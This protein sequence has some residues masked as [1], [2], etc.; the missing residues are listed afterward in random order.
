MKGC[1]RFTTS[2]R[3]PKS[4]ACFALSRLH[5]SQTSL[6]PGSS[7]VRLLC[8]LRTPR[9]ALYALAGLACAQPRRPRITVRA[10]GRKLAARMASRSFSCTESPASPGRQQ[11]VLRP[12]Q[13]LRQSFMLLS[14]LAFEPALSHVA[15][16]TAPH[17]WASLEA[18]AGLS[19]YSELSLRSRLSAVRSGSRRSSDFASLTTVALRC[20][21]VYSW[22]IR[23]STDVAMCS[24]RAT[25]DTGSRPSAPLGAEVGTRRSVLAR[26]YG[27][28][29]SCRSVCCPSLRTGPGAGGQGS[30]RAGALSTRETEAA[31]SLAVLSRRVPPRPCSTAVMKG[32]GLPMAT[33][34]RLE[35]GGRLSSSNCTSSPSRRSSP[36]GCGSTVM[37]APACSAIEMSSSR[38][39]RLGRSAVTL[40]SL[41]MWP[42]VMCSRSRGMNSSKLTAASTCCM[43]G[44][45][46]ASRVS[47]NAGTSAS[48]SEMM[49]SSAGASAPH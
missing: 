40:T 32:L 22:S 13:Y 31:P 49:R 9:Y 44:D 23:S 12:S 41:L 20:I 39:P 16:W 35:P 29:R 36:L 8:A 14:S 45:A 6:V 26:A 28:G 24:G 3:A 21:T 7:T 34:T 10:Y 11:G 25:V 15:S 37:H 5:I 19:A 33:V 2:D 43:S 47:T 30:T 42:I 27:V 46:E 1:L 38:R 17:M 48:T 4:A 18:E